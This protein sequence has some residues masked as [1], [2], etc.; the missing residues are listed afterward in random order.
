MELQIAPLASSYGL[1]VSVVALQQQP[2]RTLTCGPL[3]IAAAYHGA[4]SVT[5]TT[6]LI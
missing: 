3:R 5:V 2:P 1:L 4:K 6:W